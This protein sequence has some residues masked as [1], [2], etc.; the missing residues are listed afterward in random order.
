ME[1][2]D[3]LGS[4]ETSYGSRALNPC[5][6]WRILLLYFVC[7][8]PY[9][10]W[11]IFCAKFANKSHCKTIATK[12]VV[13]LHHLVEW[14]GSYLTNDISLMIKMSSYHRSRHQRNP[15]R[16]N[17]ILAQTVELELPTRPNEPVSTEESHSLSRTLAVT[18]NRTSRAIM[19]FCSTSNNY[20]L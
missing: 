12:V 2:H 10:I 20:F 15:A 9:W 17:A 5:F 19:Q 13:E 7:N 3:H 1:K 8:T 16:P 6:S 14:H 11:T 18:I 4:S